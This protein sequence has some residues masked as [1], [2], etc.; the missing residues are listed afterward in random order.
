MLLIPKASVG[1]PRRL[2]FGYLKPVATPM[3]AVC[4]FKYQCD[5]TIKHEL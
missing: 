2:T 3:V 4:S 1:P 5:T